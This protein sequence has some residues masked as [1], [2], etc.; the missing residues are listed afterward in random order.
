[1]ATSKLYKIVR[2]LIEAGADVDKAGTDRGSVRTTPWQ[3]AT[4]RGHD[5][6]ALLLRI[7]MTNK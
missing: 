5:E 1:M 6:I 4:Q 2:L 3:V 7:A